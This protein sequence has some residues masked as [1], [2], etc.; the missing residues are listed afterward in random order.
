MQQRRE[1]RA[2]QEAACRAAANPERLVCGPSVCAVSTQAQYYFV[3]NP[4][5]VFQLDACCR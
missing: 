5:R 1:M 2:F 4:I 3:C